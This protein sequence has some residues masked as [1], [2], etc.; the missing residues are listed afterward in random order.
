MALAAWLV[1]GPLV[2]AQAP[3]QPGPEHEWLKGL[4]GT[5]EAIVKMG[6]DES[7]GTMVYKSEL[8]GLWLVSD[9]QGE[10]AGQAFTGK[11]MD[12]YDPVRK[13]YIGIWCDSMSTSPVVS[14]GTYDKNAKVL[15]MWGE[16]PGPDGQPTKYKMTTQFKDNDTML[17]T[18]FGTGP[19][20]K[21]GP[22]FT[23]AYKRRK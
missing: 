19:D 15:T 18:M 4:E 21:E 12:G 1:F 14:E 11:G 5:W 8:G 17:W 7:R 20:G 23:I 22:M 13:K 16:G 10:F 2:L 3:P 9:F 6:E